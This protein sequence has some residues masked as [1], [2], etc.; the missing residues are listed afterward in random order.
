MARG[1]DLGGE[2]VQ[3]VG[4]LGRIDLATE[5]LRRGSH[6]QARNFAPQVLAGARG[7]ELAVDAAPIATLH[8]RGGYTFTDSQITKSTSP[9][10]AVFAVGS[11]A[12][13]RPR[14]A[15]FLDVFAS[16][17]G[18]DADVAVTW[19]GQRSDSDFSSLV[20]AITS[21]TRYMTVDSGLS[22][23]IA[24]AL[25]GYVRVD[26]LANREYME[27]LGYPAWGRSA[28]AGIRVAW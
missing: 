1:S 12:F 20:P 14:H 17:R 16:G 26:N 21:N 6:R 24:A 3:D 22:Y 27:P 13:R 2:L 7:L 19:V 5:Q 9:S 10:S 4:V 8:L 28:R 11:P 25:T 18:V 15:G 23:R